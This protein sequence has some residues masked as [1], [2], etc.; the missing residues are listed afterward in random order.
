MKT[1]Y[2]LLIALLISAG[3][4]ALLCYSPE[5]QVKNGF[6]RKD[7]YIAKKL[8]ELDMKYNSYFISGLSDS[9]IFLGNYNAPLRLFGCSYSLTDTRYEKIPFTYSSKINWQLAKMQVDSPWLYLT[10]YKT[11][12]FVSAKVPFKN[13][14]NHILQS[15]QAELILAL[16]PNSVIINGYDAEL[17]QKVLQKITLQPKLNQTNKHAHQSQQDGSFSI[18]GF[19]FLNKEKGTILFVYYYRNDFV[20]LDTNLNLRYTGKT[21]DTNSKA[22]IKVAEIEKDGKKLRT[23][24]APPLYVNK[25]GYSNGNYIYI[26]SALMADNENKEKFKQH[27][28]IDVY[29][30]DN[31]EYSH[32]IYLPKYKDKKLTGFAVRGRALIALHERYLIKYSIRD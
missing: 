5:R 18:D 27:E 11:P 3:A 8:N 19:M 24:A 12:S 26:Q 2:G 28:V 29:L 10:E 30:Q 9:R 13:E 22:K 14:R 23:L 25:R 4:I 21:I 17:K 7:I 32:S 15:I 6:N 20:C 31:G 16:S 1:L